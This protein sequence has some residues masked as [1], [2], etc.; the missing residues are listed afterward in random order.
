MNQVSIDKILSAALALVDSKQSGES[1][2]TA[3]VINKFNGNPETT[4]QLGREATEP[5]KI[6]TNIIDF[7]RRRAQIDMHENW[8]HRDTRKTG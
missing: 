5:E 3:L 8:L 4:H 1:E 6:A 2:I 7:V